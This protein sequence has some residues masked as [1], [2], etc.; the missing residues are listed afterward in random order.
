MNHAIRFALV[1]AAFTAST[2]TVMAQAGS[3]RLARSDRAYQAYAQSWDGNGRV[4]V[5]PSRSTNSGH[6]VYDGQRYVGSDPS[7]QIRSELLRDSEGN[8]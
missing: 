2:S 5:R 1:A 4:L 8:N 6:D 7:A 3:D